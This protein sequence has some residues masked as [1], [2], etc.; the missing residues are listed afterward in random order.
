MSL[1]SYQHAAQR[2]IEAGKFLD[3]RGM[4]PATS[5]NYS[6]R[7]DDGTIAL[8]VSGFHKGRLNEGGVMRVDMAGKAL[9]PKTPSAE[10]R[11]HTQIYQA[12]PDANAILH[13]HA[14]AGVVLGRVRREDHVTLAGYEML[15]AFPGIHTH[16]TA[17]RIPV[18]ENSQDMGV[19]SA[20]AAAHLR[21]GLP[22]Y[23]IRDHGFYA[24]GRD[25]DEAGR[26]AEALDYLLECEVDIMMINK[27]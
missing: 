18:F 16:E 10:T 8:T 14:R 1:P 11:L 27:K 5:G 15:K 24:W 13:V 23:I 4:A 26:I 22:A 20:A 7:L 3:A 19:L 12:Y 25:M 17:I 6:M 21:P 2:I 9:E